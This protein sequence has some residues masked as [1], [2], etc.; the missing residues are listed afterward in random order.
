[1]ERF[2]IYNAKNIN[3]KMV[4]TEDSIFKLAEFINTK[5]AFWFSPPDS[6]STCDR[7]D[8]YPIYKLADQLTQELGLDLIS[9]KGK[10]LKRLRK[11]FVRHDLPMVDDSI[12]SQ[13]GK[14]ISEMCAERTYHCV[15]NEDVQFTP[16]IFGDGN[17]C[18]H[19]C[20]SYS[21]LLLQ[22]C[23]ARAFFV[24]Y[25][26]Q[27]VCRSWLIPL[28]D[29]TGI[30]NCWG[31]TNLY[32][33]YGQSMPKNL[34]NEL[35]S[36]MLDIPLDFTQYAVDPNGIYL[37]DSTLKIFGLPLGFDDRIGLPCGTGDLEHDT[38][39][40]S[41]C[42]ECGQVIEP[43]D[44]Y[45]IFCG[46]HTDNCQCECCGNRYDRDGVTVVNGEYYCDNCFE[47]HYVRCIDCGDIVDRDYVTFIGDYRGVCERCSEN[48]MS[49]DVCGDYYLAH[50]MQT[51][52]E[53]CLCSYCFETHYG[54][55]PDCNKITNDSDL[56]AAYHGD[57]L[58]YVCE[59]CRDKNYTDCEDCNNT[60]KNSEITSIRIDSYSGNRRHVCLGCLD[61]H[62]IQCLD[63]EEYFPVNEISFNDGHPYC[64]DCLPDQIECNDCIL[65]DVVNS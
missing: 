10:Y 5:I 27:P 2:P 32:V 38:D 7:Y 30:D 6:C 29:V 61:D 11:F 25:N 13:F 35:V 44:D 22:Q 41:S 59:D 15:M 20:A 8:L 4:L 18:F 56:Y 39:D 65:D 40:Y 26:G 16:G 62:Y 24:F 34:H 37:N 12:F 63:C 36:K 58:V 45:C 60:I 23:E 3:I 46:A 14:F 21:K 51:D 53:H 1:M 33:A 9:A 17:A 47:K 52:G 57:D 49:C 55:C 43:D 31:S 64:S 54:I 28:Y 50:I 19:S 42:Q 48:Y